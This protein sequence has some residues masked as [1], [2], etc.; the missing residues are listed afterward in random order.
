MLLHVKMLHADYKL[1]QT[2]EF[3]LTVFTELKNIFT[4]VKGLEPATQPPL[5]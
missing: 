1:R 4:T 3:S 5:V 2:F